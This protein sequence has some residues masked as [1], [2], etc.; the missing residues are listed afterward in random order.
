M[1]MAR[2][3]YQELGKVRITHNSRHFT[4]HVLSFLQSLQKLINK[5]KD[6]LS[7]V[8]GTAA[9]LV[10]WPTVRIAQNFLDATDGR[11]TT[12]A[13]CAV[14]TAVWVAW[15]I[16]RLRPVMSSRFTHHPLSGRAYTMLTSVFRCVKAIHAAQIPS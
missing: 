6:D 4:T 7:Q 2:A 16:P 9:M 13:L 10:L 8:S 14:N 1:E 3:R 15:L 12:W 5:L 11:R